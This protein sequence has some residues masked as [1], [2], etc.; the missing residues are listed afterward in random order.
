MEAVTVFDSS[1]VLF[2]EQKQIERPKDMVKNNQSK[3]GASKQMSVK[4]NRSLFEERLQEM[5][6]SFTPLCKSI[7]SWI[8]SDKDDKANKQLQNSWFNLLEV[9]EIAR[10]DYEKGCIV[11]TPEWMIRFHFCP[12]CVCDEVERIFLDK[13]KSILKC[14]LIDGLPKALID[15]FISDFSH[16]MLCAACGKISQM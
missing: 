7:V 11:F 10:P 1:W 8:E 15:E 2:V 16:Q 5:E 13:A 3:M 6:P 4:F 14:F 9:L 12:N